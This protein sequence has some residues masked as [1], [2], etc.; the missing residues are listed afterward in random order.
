M[1]ERPRGSAVGD[2][3]A[4][5]SVFFEDRVKG[6]V[7]LKDDM[8]A[9]QAFTLK[10]EED[11]ETLWEKALVTDRTHRRKVEFD[12]AQL[13]AEGLRGPADGKVA[14][15]YEFCIPNT[16]ECK[17]R[18]KAIDPT[19]QFMPGSRGRIGAGKQ[20]CLCIGSTHQKN[21]RQV[22]QALANLPY[23][24]RIIECHFE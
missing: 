11:G 13:D 15:S 24:A 9:G 22:L 2:V 18:V 21:F 14:V 10:I 16:D 17:A 1:R 23:V 19:V 5:E 3:T 7:A 12:L 6:E 8:P 4:P 20:E